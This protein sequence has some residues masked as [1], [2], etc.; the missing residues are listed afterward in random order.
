MKTAEIGAR[1]IYRDRDLL[2]A[3]RD[4]RMALGM[5]MEDVSER[6]GIC[7]RY[8]NKVEIGLTSERRRELKARMRGRSAVYGT[9]VR[10]PFQMCTASAWALERAG[11]ALVVMPKARAENY[12]QVDPEM[13]RAL[14]RDVRQSLDADAMPLQVR[15]SVAW[16]LECMGLALVAMDAEEALWTVEP[17]PVTSLERRRLAA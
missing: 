9:S 15:P 10:R 8:Y 1:R 2:K 11:V 12:R 13:A 16:I 4:Q 6:A 17:D 3:M 14:W 7:D 5:T